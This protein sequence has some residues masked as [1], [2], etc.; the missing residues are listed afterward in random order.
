MEGGVLKR[1]G[2]TDE[3][4][5]TPELVAG[6]I[7]G[8]KG[9]GRPGLWC[10]LVEVEGAKDALGVNETDESELDKESEV[11]KEGVIFSVAIALGSNG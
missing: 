2:D 1:V 9:G 4:Q 8:V 10:I 6:E 11:N 7:E 5:L 3:Q